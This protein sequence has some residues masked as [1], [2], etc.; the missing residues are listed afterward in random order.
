MNQ[1]LVTHYDY[2]GEPF[3]M[4]QYCCPMSEKPHET[5]TNLADVTCQRCLKKLERMDTFRAC[6]KHLRK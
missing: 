3:P 1:P 5:S 2:R 6:V 4:P